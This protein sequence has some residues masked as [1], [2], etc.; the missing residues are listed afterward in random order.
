MENGQLKDVP[1][2][3]HDDVTWS[4][5]YLSRAMSGE[6]IPLSR[7]IRPS[8]ARGARG[9]FNDPAISSQSYDHPYLT[10]A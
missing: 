6:P 5:E 8:S 7:T 2:N 1:P 4:L 9:L 10:A 3:Y